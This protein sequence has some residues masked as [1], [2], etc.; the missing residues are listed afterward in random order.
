MSSNSRKTAQNEQ[1]VGRMNKEAVDQLAAYIIR[2]KL[3][4][5]AEE[6]AEWM[7]TETGQRISALIEKERKVQR[8]NRGS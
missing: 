4:A 2:N 5:S 8:G 3:C 7:R 1:K 6:T